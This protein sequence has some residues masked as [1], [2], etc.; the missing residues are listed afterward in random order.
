MQQLISSRY[1]NLSPQLQRAARF[2]AENPEEVATRSLRQIAASI[3]MSP[4]TFSRLAGALG[5]KNYEELR[6]SCRRLVKNQK[7]RFAE[8]AGVLR[9]RTDKGG[10]KGFFIM[11][12]GAAVIGNIEQLLNSVDPE[13]VESAAAQ[14]AAARKV[15]LVGMMSSRPFVEYMAY[16]AS[17][18]FENWH[19]L[20]RDPGSDASLIANVDHNDVALVISKEP[21]AM[22]AVRAAEQIR[23]QGAAVIGITDSISSPLCAYCDTRFFVSTETPQFFTSHTATLVLIE[24]L[25]ALVIANSSE[26]VEKR[27]ASVEAKSYQIGEYFTKP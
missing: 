14:L 5:Y 10:E 20:G 6:E 27:I 12:Q 3:D 19:V 21:Y 24:S 8:K 9:D 2:V 4:P 11:K 25:I 18:G 23:N 22:R 15:V 7:L 13:R 1:S 16:M 17:M 26:D